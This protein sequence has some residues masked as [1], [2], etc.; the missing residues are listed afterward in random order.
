VGAE[1][2]P[3]L[4]PA[5]LAAHPGLQVELALSN[6][7]QDLLRRDADVAVRMV[8]PTQAA[9]LARKVGTIPVG[10][11]A[12][13]D[14]L[15]RTP[16][17]QRPA[18]LLEHRLIGADQGRGLLDVL[19]AL[20]VKASARNFAVRTD[21]DVAQLGAVRAGLGIGVCQVP[22]AARDPALVRVLSALQVPLETWVVMHEDLR[23]VQRVRVVFE[24]LVS[25][26]GGYLAS[27]ATPRRARR[28]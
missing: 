6:R 4:L 23:R 2:L 22:L 13:A 21:S 11:Y 8:A 10:L 7:T 12:R 3:P 26:L 24:H 1:V 25:G 19:E 16:A 27:G 18:Q 14:Y 9:L 17:P 20:G 5:L 15:A 28:T